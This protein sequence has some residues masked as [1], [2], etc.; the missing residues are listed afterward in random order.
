M[1]SYLL[2][3][4]LFLALKSYYTTFTDRPIA[5]VPKTNAARNPPNYMKSK[6]PRTNL[7]LGGE[8]GGQ[9]P[10]SG[11]WMLE[12]FAGL[13]LRGGGPT[14]DAIGR[15]PKRIAIKPGGRSGLREPMIYF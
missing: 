9:S 1:A 7:A 8:I 6:A 4:I 15:T 5:L 12:T 13:N 2:S 14:D 3:H 11:M 10:K